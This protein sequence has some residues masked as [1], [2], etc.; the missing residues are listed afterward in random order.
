MKIQSEHNEAVTYVKLNNV[1]SYT[2]THT[3]PE[4]CP[5]TQPGLTS[6]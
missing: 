1:L 4:N 3:S 6:K 5:K 2:Y